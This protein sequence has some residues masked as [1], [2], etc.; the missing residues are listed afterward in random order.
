VIETDELGRRL[1]HASGALVPLAYVFDV[2]GWPVVRAV[3]TVAVVVAVVLELV[4]LQVGL[5]WWIYDRLTREYER[6][7]PA[8]YAL[9][10]V[11]AAAVVWTTPPAVAVPALLM[12]TVVDP[13][14]GVLGSGGP[15]EFKR[16]AVVGATFLL[17]LVLAVPFL[18]V[19]AAVPA[20]AVATAAD[21]VTPVVFG[22][23][24]DDNLSIPVG[25][26]VAATVALVTVPPLGL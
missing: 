9:Y 20:A 23:V 10:V 14:A 26:A 25:A 16:P 5:D 12:L 4:R 3:F 17:A 21:A 2:V 7:N 22:Y 13:V 8:G 15:E 19:R 24:V 1:V 18:P 11:G 6:D